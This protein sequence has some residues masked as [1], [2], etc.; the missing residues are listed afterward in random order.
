MKAI[1]KHIRLDK[2]NIPAETLRRSANPGSDEKLSESLKI[3]G[4]FVPLVVSELG[5]GEYAVWDGTRRVRLLRETG[6]AGSETLPA[7]VVEGDDADSVV[8][9]VNINQLRERLNAVA[10]AEAIRQLVQDHQLS[11]AE[12]GRRLLKTESWTSHTMKLWELPKPIL[13]DLRAGKLAVSHAWVLSGYA[14]KPNILDML[15]K[16]ALEGAIGHDRL[17]ALGV[18]ADKKGIKKAKQMKPHRIPMANGSWIRVEPLQKG[19]R[20]ELHLKEGSDTVDALKKLKVIL[21]DLEG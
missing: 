11:Q 18:I 19:I 13:T 20:A 9:Q 2:L 1:L 15:H 21:T 8:A 16:T 7:N 5:K 12:A 10:E 3:H 4:V 6:M 17:A 14:D